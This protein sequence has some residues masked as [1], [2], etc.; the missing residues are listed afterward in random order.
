MSACG[1]RCQAMYFVYCVLQRGGGGWH[2]SNHSSIT[3]LSESYSEFSWPSPCIILIIVIGNIF[4]K[5]VQSWL[6]DLFL[7]NQNY[8][9]IA[10]PVFG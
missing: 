3:H 9:G 4:S 1:A 7:M 10:L 8:L 6:A 5:T 2:H